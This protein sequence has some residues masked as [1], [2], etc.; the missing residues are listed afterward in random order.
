MRRAA[1]DAD[2]RRSSGTHRGPS[3]WRRTTASSADRLVYSREQAAQALGI[4]LA[5]LDRRVVPAIAT[6]KTDWGARLIPAGELE[7]YLAERRSELR[8]PR[9]RPARSGRRS[10]VPVAV[11]P[12]SARST[13]AV[14]ASPTSRAGSTVT[15]SPPAKAD[16]NGG[17]RRCRPC[18]D[19]RVSLAP[20][21][22]QAHG[23][24][25]SSLRR[26]RDLTVRVGAAP[27]GAKARLAPTLL[28]RDSRPD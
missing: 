26:L 19:G 22:R 14:S 21:S 16:A 10:T 4:S 18:S 27:S 23:D 7:R 20:P 2:A 9:W 3:P 15:V 13:P 1:S 12:A 8:T 24:R 25:N 28:A 5:T 6:V 17:H 11:V